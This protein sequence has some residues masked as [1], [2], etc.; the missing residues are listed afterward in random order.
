MKGFF[1]FPYH[2][3]FDFPLDVLS[4]LCTS[5]LQLGFVD[6]HIFSHQKVSAIIHVIAPSFIFLFCRR[7]YS[8]VRCRKNVNRPRGQI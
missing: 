7:M 4:N 2:F 5:I 8:E 3:F 1:F 6:I